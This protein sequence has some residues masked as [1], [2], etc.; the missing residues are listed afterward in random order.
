[1]TAKILNFWHL[2][3]SLSVY[4]LLLFFY[5]PST[6][7]LLKSTCSFTLSVSFLHAA[8]RLPFIPNLGIFCSQHGNKTNSKE[9]WIVNLAETSIVSTRKCHSFYQK[10]A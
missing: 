7:L 5:F 4:F 10:V 2:C 3:N 1:M 6:F 8:N 9:F